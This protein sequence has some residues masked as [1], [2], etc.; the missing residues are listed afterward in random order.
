[1]LT[2]VGVENEDFVSQD[3]ISKTFL[4]SYFPVKDIHFSKH[5]ARVS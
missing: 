3:N 1:M 5:L 2:Q 4:V